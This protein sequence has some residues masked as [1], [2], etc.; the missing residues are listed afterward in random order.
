MKTNKILLAILMIAVP[1]FG[2]AQEWDDIYADPN[3]NEPVKI[4]REPREPQKKKVVVVQGNASNME[5][6]AN[7]RDVDEYNRRGINDSSSDEQVYTN[8]TIDYEEYEYTD[9][10]VRFHDPESSIKITGAEEVIVYMDDDLYE[11]YNNR[12]W[13]TNLYFGGGWGSSFYPWYDPWYYSSW[14]S[15]WYYGRWYDPWFYGYSGY[16]GWYSPWYSGFGGYYGHGYYGGGLYGGGYYGGGYT[17]GFYDGYYS[18]LTQNR[19]GRSTGAYRRS[20]ANRTSSATAGLS[21]RSSGLNTRSAVSGGTTYSRNRG[22]STRTGVNSRNTANSSR[23][24]IID[25]SGRAIDSRTGRVVDRSTATSRSSS[26]NR[27]TQP[28]RTGSYNS[29]RSS[30]SGSYQRGTTTPT[31]SGNTYQRPTTATESSNSSRSSTYSSPSR[32][33]NTST[34]RSSTYS[35]PTRSS[36]SSSSGSSGSS[37]RSSSSGSSSSGSS[38]SSGSRR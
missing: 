30:T 7:G 11:N 5:V 21:G 34:S 37:S 31:R 28:A 35:A 13:N 18:S 6:T 2:F 8:D 12:G 32:S 4:Q 26:I 17:H 27:T 16:H 23:T 22:E 29:G 38:R 20:S 10:I 3:R 15:P 36:S 19:S 33:S 9:R 24:R 25:N 1:F 14:R